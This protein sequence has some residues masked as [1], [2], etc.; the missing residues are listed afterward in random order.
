MSDA[1]KILTVSYGTFSCTLEGFEEPFHAMKAISEYFRDLAAEDRYFGAEPPTPDTE[2]LHRIT[3]ASIQRRVEARM[4]ASGLLLRQHPDAADD[5]APVAAA[6]SDA[7]SDD[8]PKVAPVVGE[9]GELDTD[10]PAATLATE[11]P[12]GAQP[13]IEA[14]VLEPAPE[15]V[16][17]GD[18][19]QAAKADGARDEPVVAQDEPVADNSEEDI[20]EETRTAASA[21]AATETIPPAPPAAFAGDKID[22]AADHAEEEMAV[23]VPIAAAGTTA[24]DIDTAPDGADTLAAIAAALA[25]DLVEDT[26]PAVA[27]AEPVEDDSP[28]QRFLTETDEHEGALDDDFFGGGAP[29]DGASVAA[30]LANFRRASTSGRDIEDTE[31]K[32]D[33]AQ[34]FAEMT[35]PGAIDED[36]AFENAGVFDDDNA[37]TDDDDALAAAIAAATAP[38]AAAV[39]ATAVTARHDDDHDNR[40]AGIETEDT[41][42]IADAPLSPIR[43]TAAG[44]E[45]APG[46]EDEPAEAA[47]P[48]L[49]DAP[50]LGETDEADR[51]FDATESRLAHSDSTRRRAN[52]E[53]LKAAVA[54]RSAERQ[55][56]PEGHAASAD[57]TAE[58]RDDLAQVMRPRRVRVDVSRRRG[59]TRPAPLVLV[60]EQRVDTQDE[61]RPPAEPVR[62]RRVNGGETAAPLRLAET[63]GADTRPVAGETPATPPRKMANS[64]AQLAQRA[65][66]IMNRGRGDATARALDE[67]TDIA[68]ASMAADPEP[69]AA[70]EPH[71]APAQEMAA[72]TGTERTP[73]ADPVNY[74][75]IT[76]TH[77]ERFAL[78]LENSDATE[79][80]QVVEL[81]ARYAHAEFGTGTFDRPQLF[82]MIAEATDNSIS[83]EEMRNAFYELMCDGRIERIAR[84]SFRLA[85]SQTED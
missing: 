40:N 72:E 44:E 27:D 76:L 47:A 32:Q 23:S 30:R 53:H 42:G 71:P 11:T 70:P 49:R 8:A 51:L 20:A 26:V 5:A 55:L 65:S 75:E 31:Q 34:P 77:S 2:M 48:A 62:P 81:A 3:E 78:R 74:E 57:A 7:R 69:H 25:E 37:P 29:L 33:T 10:V 24:A 63:G 18:I 46:G 56:A 22:T 59:E 84:G 54:A 1:N 61:Q 64:L 82:R 39:A 43:A 14:A 45:D 38:V 60:S 68:E 85:E 16:R 41:A 79:I 58:Y 6:R 12:E 67:E 13:E 15:S 19:E 52:I 66:A 4:M 83:R 36:T 28:D 80:D 35:P 17:A 9:T 21:G 73:D 50:P